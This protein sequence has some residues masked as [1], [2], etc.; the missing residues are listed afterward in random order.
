MMPTSCRSAS[1]RTTKLTI[2]VTMVEDQSVQAGCREPPPEACIQWSHARRRK[3]AHEIPVSLVAWRLAGTVFRRITCRANL[4]IGQAVAYNACATERCAVAS[5]QQR[6]VDGL[7]LDDQAS[8][9]SAMRARSV[10]GWETIGMTCAEFNYWLAPALGSVERA[11]VCSIVAGWNRG[12]RSPDQRDGRGPCSFRAARRPHRDA[13]RD[14]RGDHPAHS[15][16][17]T[18]NHPARGTFC[19]RAAGTAGEP[20]VAGPIR[21]RR[22]A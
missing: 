5:R 11:L 2:T 13:E 6:P 16:W 18:G 8:H 4:F 21:C 7:V 19:V 3:S 20:A 12:P 1:L 15:R 17:P 22:W 10:A 9:E 14:L